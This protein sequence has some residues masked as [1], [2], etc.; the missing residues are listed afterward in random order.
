M[1]DAT[2]LWPADDAYAHW[3]ALV[4]ALAPELPAA[5]PCVLAIRGVA[6][7]AA[8]TH[9]LVARPAYDD[10]LVLLVDGTARA[11]PG[12]TH[13]Y[14][15]NS[16]ESPD[17]TGDGVGDVATI[18]PGRYQLVAL[19]A[20]ADPVLHVLALD[21]ADRIPCWRDAD[22]D[23]LYSADE[24]AASEAR[25]K[26]PQ[27]DGGGDFASSVLLHPGYDSGKSSIACQTAHLADVAACARLGTLDYLLVDAADALAACGLSNA[28][29]AQAEA[30]VALSVDAALRETEPAPPTE[31]AT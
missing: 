1:T 13:A 2:R 26:G 22:H 28:D 23:G 9:G 4:R 6:P 5:R 11:F 14:Q 24:R 12:C 19:R 30:A 27:V 8:E 17:V 21:G 20:G 25:R 15:R 3:S 7:G 10:T 18:R 29:R 16:R 31:R